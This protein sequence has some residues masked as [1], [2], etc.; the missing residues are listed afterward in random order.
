MEGASL[1]SFHSRGPAIAVLREEGEGSITLPSCKV[2]VEDSSTVAEH[3][4]PLEEVDS[5]SLVVDM[6]EL[7]DGRMSNLGGDDD[8]HHLRTEGHLLSR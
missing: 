7:P 8:L 2:E 3:S 5:S 4:N 1:A 6:K